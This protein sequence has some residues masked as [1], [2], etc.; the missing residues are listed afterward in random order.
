VHLADAVGEQQRRGPGITLL[1]CA[2]RPHQWAKNL[3]LLVPVLTGHVWGLGPVAR[4]ALGMVAF[5]LLASAAYLTNDLLDLDADRACP[6]KR[7]RPFASGRLALKWGVLLAPLLTIGGLGIASS[8]G[9]AFTAIAGTYF[10]ATV[11]YSFWLKRE[12]IVDVMVLAGLYTWR[13]LAG[14]VTAGVVLSP[15]LLAFSIFFFLSLALVKR[16]TEL[17]RSPGGPGRGY[18]TGDYPQ[19]ARLGTAAGYVA[20]LIMAL[21]IHQPETAR[22]YARP[23]LLW[24]I[25][26][27]L[28]YWV[29]R[30]WMLV[31]RDELDDDPVLFAVRDPNSYGCALIMA[32]SIFSALR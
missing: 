9:G 19:L 25:C 13:L 22:L 8:I 23:Q 4:T 5:S 26:P 27:A 29:S 3:L 10:V 7:H 28:I 14:S 11:V 1:L 32:V 6:G 17:R 20:I 12:M 18:R 30:L 31:E 21:Y 16:C 24:A 15:W 2:L